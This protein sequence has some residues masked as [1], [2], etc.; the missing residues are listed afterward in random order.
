MRSNMKS[1]NSGALLCRC[2]AASPQFLIPT[3]IEI[4]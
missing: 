1:Y 3:C 4:S 2:P